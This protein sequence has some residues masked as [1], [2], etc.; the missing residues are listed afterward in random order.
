M[1]KAHTARVMF[2]RLSRQVTPR[3]PR[4]MAAAKRVFLA[5]LRATRLDVRYFYDR[6][7]ATGKR[8]RKPYAGNFAR[9]VA[10]HFKPGSV[11][12]VGCGTGDILAEFMVLGI[13]V[14]GVDGSPAC[15]EHALIPSNL[16][17]VW[18]LR[19]PLPIESP[20]DLVLCLEVAEHIEE[21]WAPVLVDGLARAGRHLVFSA[22]EPGQGG[23]DHCNLKPRE[24]WIAMIGE[25][26]LVYL[27]RD[28]AKLAEAL[29]QIEGIDPYY[30]KNLIVAAAPAGR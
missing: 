4:M 18:D 28:T 30:H 22:A 27:E 9:I 11:L 2:E 19:N 26:G 3:F 20:V 25:S 23:L 8:R 1:S 14:R 17:T 29:S 13:E 10:D 21:R 16:F 5:V 12:D 7:F 24:W 15:R 6:R